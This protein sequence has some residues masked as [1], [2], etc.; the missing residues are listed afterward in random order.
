M[1]YLNYLLQYKNTGFTRR[2][3]LM[4]RFFIFDAT[5]LVTELCVTEKSRREYFSTAQISIVES[6]GVG[7]LGFSPSWEDFNDGKKYPGS[8]QFVLPVSAPIISFL[9]DGERGPSI[10]VGIDVP[11]QNGALTHIGPDDGGEFVWD[12]GIARGLSAS[13]A[14][15]GRDCMEASN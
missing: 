5:M 2:D 15:C 12:L 14:N 6:N 7:T 8:V 10:Q 13:L 11:Y 3:G 4:R 1:A 9:A